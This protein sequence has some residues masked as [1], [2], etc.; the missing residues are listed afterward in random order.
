MFQNEYKPFL[1]LLSADF[2]F[3]VQMKARQDLLILSNMESDWSKKKNCLKKYYK[4]RAS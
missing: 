4:I 2:R 3:N 1:V